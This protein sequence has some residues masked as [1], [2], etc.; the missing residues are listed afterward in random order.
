[1]RRRRVEVFS[2]SFLD[3]ICCGFGAVVLFYTIIAGQAGVKR[4]GKRRAGRG[5]PAGTR[6][7]VGTRNLV[8][9]RNTLQKTQSETMQASARASALLDEV[10]KR[11]KRPCCRCHHMRS[12]RHQKLKTDLKQLEEGTS[13][14]AASPAAGACRPARACIRGTGNR[15][16]SP[17]SS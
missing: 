16:T 4:T 8:V 5:Q 1:M 7:L 17:A 10:G 6:V 13:R 9:L 2:L 12:A 3:C 15:S 11:A 14:L